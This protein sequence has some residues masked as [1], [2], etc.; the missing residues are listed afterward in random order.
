MTECSI[1]GLI[2]GVDLDRKNLQIILAKISGISK[3]R[4]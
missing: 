2:S 3:L 4:L 1:S